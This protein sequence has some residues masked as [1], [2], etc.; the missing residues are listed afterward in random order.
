MFDF[1]RDAVR[2]FAY[3]LYAANKCP[4]QGGIGQESFAG[5]T[6]FAP[7]EILCLIQDVPKVLNR[8]GGHAPP[9]AECAGRDE[10]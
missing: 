1:I 3:D 10:D 7:Q 9:G 6:F 2:G 4:L 5:K 8:R